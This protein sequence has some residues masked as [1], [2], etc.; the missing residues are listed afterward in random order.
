MSRKR[1]FTV[2]PQLWETIQTASGAFVVLL[3][4]GYVLQLLRPSSIVPLLDEF[5][6]AAKEDGLA[7]VDSGALMVGIFL[8]NLMVLLFAILIGLIPFIRLPALDLGVNAMLIG[9][10]GAY[11]QQNGVSLSVYLVGVLPHGITEMTALVLACAAGLSLNRAVNEALF[12]RE[13]TGSVNRAVR[14]SFGIYARLITPLLM[15]SAWIETFITP[16]LLA[17]FL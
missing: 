5:S 10:M 7:E 9:A 6:T 14:E 17:F 16:K 15:V 12:R 4:F 11:C 3:I 2:S 1:H 8:S 13:E